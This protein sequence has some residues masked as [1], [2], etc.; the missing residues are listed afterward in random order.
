MKSLKLFLQQ[1]LSKNKSRQIGTL[2]MG[3]VLVFVVAN[4]IMNGLNGNKA[5]AETSDIVVT[6]ETKRLTPETIE[7][8]LNVSSKVSAQNEVKVIPK[9][10]GTVKSVYVKV[11]DAVKAGDVLFA[12]DDITQQLQAQQAAAQLASAQAGYEMNVG[13]ALENQILQLESSVD[14][15]EI[16]YKDLLKDLENANVLYPAGAMSKQGLDTIQSNVDKVKLQLDAT[17]KNLDLAKGKTANSTR[18]TAQASVEQARVSVVSAETQLGHTKVKAEIDGI[19]SAVNVT[20]GTM[21]SAQ[22]PAV[23]LVDLGGLKAA[24][25]LSDDHINKIAAGS[26]AYVTVGAARKT[27]YTGTVVSMAPTADS[28]TQLYPVE[29][30]LDAED[31]RLKPGM[32]A[33]VKLVVD[34]K[35]NSLAVPV[36]AVIEKGEEKFVYTLTEDGKAKKHVVTTGISN[37]NVIELLTGVK[38]GDTVIIKGQS[39]VKDGDHVTVKTDK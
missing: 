20:V 24:F 15:Y 5:N 1:L 25:S 39:F 31:G 9:V 16:Q 22:S 11:G 21:A 29:V 32:F 38:A 4:G 36:N 3:W 8:Y 13:S 30:K 2:L 23:T 18:K 19:V 37:E 33:S 7:A 6:V 28:T 12:I 14:S 17:R 35:D 26:A 27:P 34:R 10:S